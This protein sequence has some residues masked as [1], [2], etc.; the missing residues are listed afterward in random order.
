M[1]Y[2]IFAAVQDN[3]K[4]HHECGARLA[5]SLLADFAGIDTSESG[6]LYTK[7]GKPYVSAPDAEFSI[8]HSGNIAACALWVRDVR[9]DAPILPPDGEVR[10]EVVY[11]FDESDYGITSSPGMAVRVGLDVET[12]K[13][14]RTRLDLIAGRYFSSEEYAYITGGGIEP[15][16]FYE[17]WTRYESYGKMLGCG[18]GAL[19]KDSGGAGFTSAKFRSFTLSHGGDSYAVSLCMEQ[20]LQ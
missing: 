16:R 18:V 10:T 11:A 5:A 12:V 15:R 9:V 2:L 14:G 19:K 4:A 6:F 13:Q 1:I 17:V 8:S 3:R 7:D 20:Y